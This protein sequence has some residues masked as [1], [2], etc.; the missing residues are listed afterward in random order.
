MAEHK[1]A[2]RARIT[3]RV[4]GVGFREWTRAEAIGLGIAGWVRNERDGSVSALLVGSQS[5]V[6]T[7]LERLWTG[8]PLAMVADVK[9][10]NETAIEMPAD[11]R[12]TR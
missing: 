8:P 3:G 2:V 1:R 9:P 6:A 7:M 4:Q 5:A 11:F 12:V 10:E